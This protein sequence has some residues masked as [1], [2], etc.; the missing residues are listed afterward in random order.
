MKL[1]Q[2]KCHFL[3]SGDKNENI[4]ANI[5][6]EKNWESNKQ[7]L[8]GLDIDRN[9]NFISEHVFYLC[10]KPGNELSLLT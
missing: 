10:R 2:G 9:L 4:W 7:K 8:L 5:A 3:V 6:N 1:N